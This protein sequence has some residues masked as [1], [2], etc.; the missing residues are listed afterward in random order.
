M[1]HSLVRLFVRITIVP[2][3]ACVYREISFA[4]CTFIYLCSLFQVLL[5]VLPSFQLRRSIGVYA[6]IKIKPPCMVQVTSEAL[7]LFVVVVGSPQSTLVCM[8]LEPQ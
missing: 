8:G 3:N 4:A 2:L 1:L 7:S 6:T 5:T